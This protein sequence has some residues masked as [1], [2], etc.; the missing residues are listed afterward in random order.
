MDGEYSMSV[1]VL[2]VSAAVTAIVVLISPAGAEETHCKFLPEGGLVGH[3][4][5]LVGP[6][7]CKQACT[8]TDGC[9]AWSYQPH[10]FNPKNGPGECRMMSA[11]LEE[12][13]DTRDFCGR[14]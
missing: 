10:N 12:V 5:E 7:A 8:E 14:V 6:V 1:N 9:T 4:Y 11:V 2:P 3:S 13:D